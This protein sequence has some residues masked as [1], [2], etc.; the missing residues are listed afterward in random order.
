MICRL[1]NNDKTLGKSHVIPESFFPKIKNAPRPLKL[2]TNV[3]GEFPKKAQIGVYDKTILCT[4]CEKTF[5]LP[6]NYAQKLLLEYQNQHI[7]VS[8]SFQSIGYKIQNYDY[9]LL[10]LFFVSLL[11]RASI[12][13]HSFYEG[14]RLGPFESVA[15]NLLKANQSIPSEVF[16][17]IL[18]K[19]DDPVGKSILDPFASKFDG[20][21]F[22]V[23][24]L[25]GYVAYIK[26][27][28][29]NTPN[30]FSELMMSPGRPLLI[31]SRE[32]SDSPEISLFRD[33]VRTS[34]KR[35]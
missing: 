3:A 27:D 15:F 34:Y 2:L 30:I 21:N 24:Y 23:F 18:A 7:P 10:K 16:S 29:R 28:K 12:S 35:A 25:G 4:E 20:V 19:F 11:W 9:D 22:N 17:V 1:C 13:S 6:D 26:S 32:L 5:D 31:F 33:I 14:I 8:D